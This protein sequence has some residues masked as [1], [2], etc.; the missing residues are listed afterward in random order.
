MC[1]FYGI[2]KAAGLVDQGADQ[3]LLPAEWIKL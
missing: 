1:D 2:V 3:G